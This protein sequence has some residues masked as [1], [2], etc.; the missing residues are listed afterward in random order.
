[1]SF[2]SFNDKSNPVLNYLV[3]H[4]LRENEHQKGLRET[5]LQHPDRLMMGAPEEAQFLAMVCNLIGAKTAVEVG[6][7][8][9]YT[10]LTLAQT[11]PK[12]GKIYA[13]DISEEYTN[14]GKPFWQAAGVGDRVDL[15]LGPA[16]AGLDQLLADGL[17]GTVDF[18][19]IDAVKTE[20]DAYYERC[21]KLLRPGGVIAVDNVLWSGRVADPQQ[22]SE[23]TVAI[24]A[25]NDKIHSDTRVEVSMLPLSD[26]VY[27]CR[28][29]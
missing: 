23:A 26:G 19:F 12:D 21:L 13:L 15:R 24:R 16:I 14:I 10:T 25:L 18:A 22:N 1:M 4:S 6:V 9:G 27:L 2:K 5:T 3:A 8:T 29:L 7:F 11:L 20:Y 17:E 28:K